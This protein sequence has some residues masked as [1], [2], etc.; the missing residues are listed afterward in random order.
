MVWVVLSEEEKDFN[1]PYTPSGGVQDFEKGVF[2][3]SD[4][5]DLVR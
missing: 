4:N 5:S 3:D 1:L 2:A